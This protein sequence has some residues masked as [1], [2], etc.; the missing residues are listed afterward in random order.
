[1]IM[2]NILVVIFLLG[3][4]HVTAQVSNK[5]SDLPALVKSGDTIYVTTENVRYIIGGDVHLGL[6]TLP[7]GNFKFIRIAR[8]NPKTI[9]LYQLKSDWRGH[10]F[11]I[12]DVFKVGSD[13]RGYAF[14]LE[15]DGGLAVNYECDI[16]NALRSGEVV[17][18][19]YTPPSQKPVV[20]EQQHLSIADELKKLKELKDEGILTQDEFDTQKQKLLSK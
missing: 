7:N 8:N 20:V 11:R 18:D 1:M 17:V 15:I 14:Y 9:H 13:D 10:F 5:Y 4:F 16:V 6:G 12:K 3:S 2:R 19:G